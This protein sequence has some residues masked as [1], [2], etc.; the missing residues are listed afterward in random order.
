MGAGCSRSLDRFAA[1]KLNRLEEGK[2]VALPVFE[3]RNPIDPVT[4]SRFMLELMHKRE[5]SGIFQVGCRDSITRYHMGLKLAS[6]M[7]HPGQVTAQQEPTPGRAP[8]FS[9]DIA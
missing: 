6:R 2:S 4:A 5:T 1:Q 8:L 9:S 7:G 3:Q